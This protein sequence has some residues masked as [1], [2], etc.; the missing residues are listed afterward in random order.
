MNQTSKSLKANLATEH[1]DPTVLRSKKCNLM[2]DIAC[3]KFNSK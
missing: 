1:P 3:S 2:H